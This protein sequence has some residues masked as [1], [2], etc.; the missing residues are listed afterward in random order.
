MRITLADLGAPSGS[1][2]LYY[3][4]SLSLAADAPRVISLSEVEGIYELR[5]IRRAEL[6]T[7]EVLYNG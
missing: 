6:K 4:D 3:K 5:L 7:I 1:L 2:F